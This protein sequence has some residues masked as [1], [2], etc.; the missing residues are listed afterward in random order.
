MYRVM[1]PG[2][3]MAESFFLD[4]GGRL[5]DVRIRTLTQ[6]SERRSAACQLAQA[7]DVG[8]YPNA[9]RAVPDIGLIES[10]CR[11]R[12]FQRVSNVAG[13]HGRTQLPGHDVS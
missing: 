8:R 13:L 6:V 9:Y 4:G 2:F 5:D 10:R 12:H 11:Q 3:A 1:D 7:P